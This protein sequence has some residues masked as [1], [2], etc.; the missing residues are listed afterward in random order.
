M[1]SLLTRVGRY[2]LIGLLLLGGG[3]PAMAHRHHPAAVAPADPQDVKFAAFVADFRA[4]ALAAGITPANYD[5][6]M[7]GIHRN[8]KVEALAQSQPEFVKPIWSY[9]DTADSPA[10]VTAGQKALAA[11]YTILTAL[12]ARS[13]VP[14]E[15]LVSIWGNET[16]Y[17]AGLGTFNIFEA[18]ATLAYD[19]ART[20]FGRSELLCALKMMQQENLDPAQMISSWAGAFGQMQMLPSTFLKIAVDGDGDGRRDLW[21]S[22]PDSLA[23]AAAEVVNDGWQRGES[24]GYEVK[25]PPGFAYEQADGDT[26]K[27]IGAWS[28]LG[29]RRMDGTA[30]PPDPNAAAIYLPAGARGPALL[31]FPNF[32]VILKYNNAMSYALAVCYLG[33]LIAGR[34]PI[35]A[36]WPRDEQPLSSDERIAFQNALLKLGYDPGKIDGVLGRGVKGALRGY[37]K[38]HGLP[39]DGFPTEGLLAQMLTEVKSKGL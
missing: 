11:Q 17:G 19:G 31:I 13:G 36:S 38:S 20:D 33:D 24:W 34:T 9:L 6:A 18:L 35:L 25:L 12:E 5:R 15:I 27:P 22:A 37:Q 7:T 4:T 28:E 39:A 26:M 23:S 2:G 32:K 8:R 29:V 14:K 30:L 16:A 10:R 3:A 21:H 1:S